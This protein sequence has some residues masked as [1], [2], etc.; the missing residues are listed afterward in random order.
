MAD[1]APILLP[2][3]PFD[4]NVGVSF[5][6]TFTGSLQSTANNVRITDVETG[7]AVYDFI[8]NGFEKIHPIPPAELS[9][10][11]KYKAKIRVKY[12]DGSFSPYSE[13]VEF[14]AI[15]TPVL[16]IDN[17]DGQGYVYN[18]DVTFTARYTQ[19]DGELVKTYRFSLYDENETLIQ[20]YPLR[21]PEDAGVVLTETIKGL[22]KGKGYFIEVVIETK[23]GFVWSD[24]EKFIPIYLV[25]AVHGIIQTEND[26]DDG[27]VRVSAELKQI[28]GTQVRATD[29]ND[30]YI[31][32]NYQYENNEWIIVPEDNPVI[33]RGL[34][35]NRASDFVMKVWCKNVPI[36]TK[37]LELSPKGDTDIPIQFWRY[38]DRVVA[39]KEY[40]GIRSRHCSNILEIPESSQF[41]LYAK[42]IEH[43]IDLTLRLI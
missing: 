32:D 10:G 12:S 29:P 27:F 18:S 30:Q 2:I 43:R 8:Y 42:A 22:E 11:K 23:N 15:A 26:S 5:Y 38:E 7:L 31:S 36:G 35:M 34:G 37:F 13:E 17:I 33:F 20:N 28:L 41:M 9:N 21:Y 1:I 24:R 25:P 39:V 6:Y 3:A 19:T 16:D 14:L 4:A 40:A